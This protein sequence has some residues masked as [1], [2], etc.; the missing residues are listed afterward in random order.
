MFLSILFSLNLIYFIYKL[1]YKVNLPG[2]YIKDNNE[3]NINTVYDIRY[4]F[5]IISCIS[6]I[7]FYNVFYYIGFITTLYNIWKL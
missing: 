6:Y 2:L 3:Y 1:D 5:T 4:V 7:F